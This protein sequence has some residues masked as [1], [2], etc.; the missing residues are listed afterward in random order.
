MGG[1]SREYPGTTDTKVMIVSFPD[2]NSLIPMFPFLVISH[3]VQHEPP[4]YLEMAVLTCCRFMMRNSMGACMLSSSPRLPKPASPV[5]VRGQ[6]LYPM[7]FAPTSGQQAPRMLYPGSPVRPPTLV[8]PFYQPAS[9][10]QAFYDPQHQTPGTKRLT[11][12]VRVVFKVC[13]NNSKLNSTFRLFGK[14]SK[15]WTEF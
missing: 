10:Q 8:P 11:E 4:P 3:Q 5:G 7:T 2:T 12:Q 1:D 14:K 9:P 13:Y 15:H 6:V